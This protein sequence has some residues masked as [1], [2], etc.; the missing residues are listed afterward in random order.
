MRKVIEYTLV[1]A[2]GAID[3]PV[4]LGSCNTRTTP[5]CATGWAC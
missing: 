4:N 5:T 1:S 3:D 2:D